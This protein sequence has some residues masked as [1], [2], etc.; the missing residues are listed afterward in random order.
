M[1]VQDEVE[2]A[3]MTQ[4]VADPN[5][6]LHFDTEVVELSQTEQETMLV[7]HDIKSGERRTVTAAYT[8]AA[9]GP[10]SGTRQVIG[11]KLDASPQSV[12]MQDVIF[13]AELSQYVGE[14]KGALLYTQPPEGITIFQPLDGL[15]RWRC[16]VC[17]LYTS[18]SPRD[19]TLSR[20]PSSA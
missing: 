19:A 11:A 2:N 13:H 20:M 7:L 6:T 1:T 4:V 3:L 10:A 16:Q 14:R 18:P 5:I 8:L 9:D 12:H 15:R 17:L